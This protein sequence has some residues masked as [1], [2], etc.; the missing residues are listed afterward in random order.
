MGGVSSIVR[1]P[2]EIRDLIGDL[3][4]RGRT[5]DEIKAALEGLDVDVSRSALGRH[6]KKLNEAV[7]RIRRSK[8][9]SEAIVGAMGTEADTQTLRGNVALMSEVV[10]RIIIT[11][12]QPLEGGD[13]KDGLYSPAGVMLTSKALEHLARTMRHD[14][15]FVDKIRAQEQAKAEAAMRERLQKILPETGRDPKEMTTEELE[16]AIRERLA[17]RT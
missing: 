4:R 13:G 6:R 11:A 1:L 16:E 9:I 2:P 8:A 14:A 7:E 15:E 3:L 12:S 17:A 10:Q 5:L